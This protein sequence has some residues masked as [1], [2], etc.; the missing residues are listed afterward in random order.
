MSNLAWVDVETTGLDTRHCALLEVGLVV[1]TDEL[2]IVAAKS[3][4]CYYDRA[5][6]TLPT[7]I[8]PVVV[9]MH[10]KNGLWDECRESRLGLM[11]IEDEGIEF[12]RTHDAVRSPMCGSTVSFDRAV[13]LSHMPRLALLF[14]Y[15]HIDVSSFVEVCG[16]WQLS[17]LPE[18]VDQ[19]TLPEAREHR[20]LGDLAVSIGI[21]R[22]FRRHMLKTP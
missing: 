1:T 2:D 7:P 4:V 11:Q 15:R 20:A 17:I 16:R 5:E 6:F 13:L 18:E 8:A 21:L 10:T 14:H 19:V 12:L 22:S 3:W 9:D